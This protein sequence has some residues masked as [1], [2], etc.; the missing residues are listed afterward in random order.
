L[1]GVGVGLVLALIL[2]RA[3]AG[4]LLDVSALDPVV[5]TLAAAT[6]LAIGQLASYLP[7]RSASR[8]D[9]VTTL[10]AE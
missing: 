10:R 6:M 3:L 5:F 4:L 1:I 7:A 8:I 2:A 9:P